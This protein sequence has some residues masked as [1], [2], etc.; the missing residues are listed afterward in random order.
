MSV[1]R[2]QKTKEKMN[3][4]VKDLKKVMHFAND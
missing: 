1:A 4:F 2:I 3:I